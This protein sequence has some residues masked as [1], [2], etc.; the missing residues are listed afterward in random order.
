MST[1]HDLDPETCRELAAEGLTLVCFW[2]EWSDECKGLAPALGDLAAAYPELFVARVDAA[3]S[4]Q[5]MTEAGVDTVPSSVLF[6]DGEP[7]RS[8]EL[9]VPFPA[10][11]RELLERKPA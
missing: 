3:E 1:I 6:E 7:V 9:G 11:D 2:A 8:F 5:L 10:L 4:E